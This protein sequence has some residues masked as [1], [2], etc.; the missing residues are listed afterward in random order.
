MKKDVGRL[1][2][3]VLRHK[4]ETLSL[5]LDQNGWVETNILLEALK[6]KGFDTSMEDLE[7]IVIENNKQRFIFNEDKTKIK[8]NQGHSIKIDLELRLVVPPEALYH[9]TTYRFL[10]AI[11]EEGLKK[12]KRHH[13]HLSEDFDTAKTVGERRGEAI[14]LYIDSYQMQL[15]GYEFFKTANNVWLTDSVPAKYIKFS[16]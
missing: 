3:L 4:P 12:M 1:L 8:A 15:D 10:K 5:T 11:K 7:K 2:S 14:I 13:V 16:I 6:N 9:G